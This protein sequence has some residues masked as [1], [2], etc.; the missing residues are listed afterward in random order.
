MPTI[1]LKEVA[2]LKGG[3][4]SHQA[5]QLLADV[6]RAGKNV[7]TGSDIGD[8]KEVNP[9]WTSGGDIGAVLRTSINL[10]EI[11][12]NSNTPCIAVNSKHTRPVVI[13]KGRTQLEATIKAIAG[14]LNSPFGGVWGFNTG[15]E[16]DTSQFLKRMFFVG[17]VA[18]EYEK[19]AAELLK[20]KILV[21]T[22]NLNSGN[23]DPFRGSLQPLPLG[24]FLEQEREPAFDV[25]NEAVVVT[26]NN[27]N[28]DI[29]SLDAQLLDDIE[30]AGNAAIYLA[31][32][33][34]FYVHDG[35]IAGLGDGCGA[36]TVA[37]RKA[38]NMLQDSAYAAL[39][40][41]TLKTWSRALYDT[42]FGMDDFEG[43]I[44]MPIRLVAFS[45]AFFPKLDGFVETA[46]I[47]RINE[48]FQSQRVKYKEGKETKTFIPKRDNYNPRYDRALIPE[49]VVQPGGSLGDKVILPI[50]EQYDV[51]MVFT[52]TPEQFELYKAGEKDPITKKP[53]TGRRFFGHIIMT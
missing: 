11:Y 8:P 49:V 2:Q 23:I 12:R 16:Y 45:D 43:T 3:E 40:A 1:K 4:N 48:D 22:G 46:G 24:Y 41:D 31:S 37:A 29:T 39:S 47:D 36:R 42:P 44:K 10:G 7:Y 34:V 53:V 28:P 18:P 25:T 38:R 32:N 26:G 14:D 15:L 13:A 6:E 21:E 20:D 19:Q 33:L 50:A 35:A 30:F 5:A 9:G 17:V 52:M 27:G 51:K